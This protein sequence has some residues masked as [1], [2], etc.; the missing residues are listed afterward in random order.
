M[1][2]KFVSIRDQVKDVYFLKNPV[3]RTEYNQLLS[4]KDPSR[5]EQSPW[6]SERCFD[7]P[8]KFDES[9]QMYIV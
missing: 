1:L 7:T 9:I 3:K 8:G 5:L 2:G 4:L 6:I